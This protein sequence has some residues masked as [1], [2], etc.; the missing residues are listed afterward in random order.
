MASIAATFAD[1]PE[2]E[3]LNYL[4]KAVHRGFSRMEDQF[5][6][7]DDSIR[8]LG[9]DIEERDFYHDIRPY[10]NTLRSLRENVNEYINEY[11]T[12]DSNRRWCRE[13][14]DEKRRDLERT[15]YLDLEDGLNSIKWA[16][17]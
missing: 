11:A 15:D 12:C 14:Q 5:D 8:D 4:I 13:T 16:F 6:D 1:S 10:R 17:E 9:H 3:R 7:L 2:V